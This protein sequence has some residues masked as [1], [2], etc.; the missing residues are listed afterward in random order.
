MKKWSVLLVLAL[1]AGTVLACS[2][3]GTAVDRTIEEARKEVGAGTRTPTLEPEPTQ[4]PEP[5]PSSIPTSEPSPTAAVIA[6]TATPVP[7]PTEAVLP[8]YT[9]VP[10][11][12]EQPAEE[13]TQGVRV[14]DGDTIAVSMNGQE[15]KVRYIGINTPETDQPGGYEAT[16]ANRALV[17]GQ[18]LRMVKDVSEVDQYGRLLRYVYV[19]GIFVNAELV[20]QGYAEA[21]TYPPDVAHAEEF[22]TLQGQAREAGVGLWAVE[23]SP[24]EP[25]PPEPGGAAYIGNANTKKFHYAWCDSVGDMNPENQVPFATREEAIAAGYVPCKRCNP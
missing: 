4:P 12:A 5:S 7:E 24:T 8:T 1:L 6:A 10:P 9:P 25:P 2:T 13:M 3:A 20:R 11:E 17:E 16:A 22:V 19:G 21:A 18:Q 15:Y 14:L 23:A